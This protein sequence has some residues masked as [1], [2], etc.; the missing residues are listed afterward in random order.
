M[1]LVHRTVKD[2]IPMS[3]ERSEEIKAKY[4]NDEDIDYSDIP[5]LDDDFLAECQVINFSKLSL[6]KEKNY[7]KT[8]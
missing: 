8:E 2:I 6:T 3:H 4:Q 7:A 1:S 5:P